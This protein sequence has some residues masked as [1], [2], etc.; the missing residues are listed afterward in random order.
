MSWL[1]RNRTVVMAT[2][3]N[4]A[5]MGA[6][7]L[8]LRWPVH[9]GI[10]IVSP[11]SAPPTPSAIRV[12]VSGAV[13]RPDVVELPRGSIVRDAIAAA[14]G[15]TADADLDSVNLA[16]AVSDAAQVNVPRLGQPTATPEPSRSSPPVSL[17]KVNLNT[18]TLAD[19]DT[20]PGIGPVTAQA[21]IDYRASHGPFVSIESLL[22]VRGIG[23][24]TLSKIR[25]LVA[26]R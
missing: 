4:I 21:I 19:L 10:E 7:V 1:T 20:L 15:A 18:A 22:S 9:G 13:V 16:A 26:V 8:A 2:L 12:Y 14:G 24:S 5:A 17:G 11:T 6:V 23:E 25:D 3:L